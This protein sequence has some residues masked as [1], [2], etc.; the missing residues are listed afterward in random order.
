[1]YING[2]A[3][4]YFFSI[5]KNRT[6]AFIKVAFPIS[7]VVYRGYNN[8]NSFGGLSCAN[9]NNDPSNSNSNVGSRLEIKESAYN[10][11]DVSPPLSR[12]KQASVKAQF[13]EN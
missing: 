5:V 11:G 3:N 13:V 7:R 10:T 4:I 8:A 6:F 9:A 12:G 1:M 2:E